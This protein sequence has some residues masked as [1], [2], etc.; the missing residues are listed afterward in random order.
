MSIIRNVC[1]LY[2]D[3]KQNKRYESEIAAKYLPELTIAFKSLD[4]AY[5]APMS[6]INAVSHTFVATA[7]HHSSITLAHQSSLKPKHKKQNEIQTDHT[8]SA[9]LKPPLARK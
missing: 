8:S 2:L 4:T 7:P 9:S 6:V 3:A 1:D 5:N